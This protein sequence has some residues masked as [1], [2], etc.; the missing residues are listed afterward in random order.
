MYPTLNFA[1]IQVNLAYN[2]FLIYVIF[3]LKCT[4]FG[5]FCS[6][7]KFLLLLEGRPTNDVQLFSEKFAHL[8]F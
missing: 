1:L 6:L 2:N 4:E 5:L 8:E 7:T 3:I